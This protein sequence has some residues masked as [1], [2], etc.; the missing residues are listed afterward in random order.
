MNQL[1]LPALADGCMDGRRHASA[2]AAPERAFGLRAA[3]QAQ[4]FGDGR[5]AWQAHN[6][7]ALVH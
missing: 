5:V 1:T 7:Q 6:G 4:K 2:A 3:P